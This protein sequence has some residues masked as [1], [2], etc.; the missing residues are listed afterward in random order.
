MVH[1]DERPGEKRDESATYGFKI[2]PDKNAYYAGRDYMASYFQL[3]F[4]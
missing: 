3:G 2:M 4:R 1:V